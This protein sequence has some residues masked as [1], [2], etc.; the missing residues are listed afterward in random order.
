MVSSLVKEARQDLLSFP[1]SQVIYR[2]VKI[3]VLNPPGV[4]LRLYYAIH[5]RIGHASDPIGAHMTSCIVYRILDLQL[6]NKIFA[7]RIAKR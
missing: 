3:R 1:E 5:I 2:Q 7:A 6:R 4:S